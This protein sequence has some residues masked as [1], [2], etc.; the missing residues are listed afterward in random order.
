MIELLK[1]FMKLT[2]P[3]KLADLNSEDSQH[4]PFHAYSKDLKGKY[5]GS[6]NYL[7]NDLGFTSGEQLLGY[8]DT[9]LWP[10]EANHIKINDN[11]VVKANKHIIFLEAGNLI[12]TGGQ[13]SVISHKMPLHACS[14]KVIGI[15]GLS[16][17]LKNGNN[18]F[19]DTS[20]NINE[21]KTTS[22]L[23]SSHLTNRQFQCLY[24]LVKGMTQKEIAKALRLSPC[25]VESYLEEIKMKL[26]YTSRHELISKALKLESIRNRLI[27][28]F[29]W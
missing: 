27:F 26:K 25:T 17:I 21:K 8:T 15:M 12:T 1:N 16:F 14:G 13:I 18:I 9:D 24:Y 20:V 23:T 28:D 6:N 5:L 7:A 29:C 4:L 19:I 3:E 2:D 11:K 22:N 10:T